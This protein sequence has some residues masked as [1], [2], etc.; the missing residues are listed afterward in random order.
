MSSKMGINGGTQI[1]KRSVFHD[2]R[3]RETS[4]QNDRDRCETAPDPVRLGRTSSSPFGGDRVVSGY[5]FDPSGLGMSR[6]DFFLGFVAVSTT[7][8]PA[9]KFLRPW[10]PLAEVMSLSA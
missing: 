5:P 4:L 10:E 1:C 9:I 6:G 2:A 8:C 7:R 3:L